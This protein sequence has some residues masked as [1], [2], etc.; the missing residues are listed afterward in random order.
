MFAFPG[1]E[2]KMKKQRQYNIEHISLRIRYLRC[3]KQ[4]LKVYDN[5]CFDR[6]VFIGCSTLSLKA[7]LRPFIVSAS[8]LLLVVSLF[9]LLFLVDK[10]KK[11][12]NLSRK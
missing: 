7:F 5:V 2:L 6:A 4:S 10:N 8:E 11:K 1:K 9:F 12:L 3:A